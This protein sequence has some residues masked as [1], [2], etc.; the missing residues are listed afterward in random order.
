MKIR[1]NPSVETFSFYM[2]LLRLDKPWLPPT[3]KRPCEEKD[4]GANE[5]EVP[6][7]TWTFE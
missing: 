1:A 2:T 4:A 5:G 6:S 3:Q 7:K